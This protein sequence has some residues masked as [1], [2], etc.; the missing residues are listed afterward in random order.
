[1]LPQPASVNSE[2]GFFLAIGIRAE[3]DRHELRVAFSD[4]TEDGPGRPD[5]SL[6]AELLLYI[7]AG[8]TLIP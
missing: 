4:G 7:V 1:M 8:E 5:V 2:C 6:Y 3:F